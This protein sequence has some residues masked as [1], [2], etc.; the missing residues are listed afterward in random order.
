M[1]KSGWE[2]RGLKI[3]IFDIWLID[4]AWGQKKKENK[5]EEMCGT[6]CS[7]S[8]I[9]G[10]GKTSSCYKYSNQHSLLALHCYCFAFGVFD[11]KPV[12]TNS[13]SKRFN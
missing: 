1:A 7:M 4:S 12:K 5:V 6:F 2:I 13:F 10:I 11:N 8:P 9:V 3:K